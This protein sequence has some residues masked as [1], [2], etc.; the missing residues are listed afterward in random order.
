MMT[1]LIGKLM[2]NWWTC[3]LCIAIVCNKPVLKQTDLTILVIHWAVAS[4]HSNV[5]SVQ[6]NLSNVQN[7]LCPIRCNI[8]PHISPYYGRNPAPV[9]RSFIPLFIGCQPSFWWCRISSIHSMSHYITPMSLS[10]YDRSSHG[11]KLGN[12]R[13]LPIL[14]AGYQYM[15]NLFS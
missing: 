4:R 5:A 2:I 1:F 15:F 10:Q 13:N 6:R 8:C 7:P 11:Q 12:L 14:E 3:G 9:D